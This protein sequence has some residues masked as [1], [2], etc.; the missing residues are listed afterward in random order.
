[1]L[2]VNEYF[3]LWG[4]DFLSHRDLPIRCRFGTVQ[5]GDARAAVHR[6]AE[7]TRLSLG[8]VASL[9]S[10]LLF[11]LAKFIVTFMRAADKIIIQRAGG[12]DAFLNHQDLAVTRKCL[13]LSIEMP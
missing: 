6:L 3:A 2:S 8:V 5:E 7:T 1:V 12:G 13:P 10:P 9:Q 4:G 11:Y